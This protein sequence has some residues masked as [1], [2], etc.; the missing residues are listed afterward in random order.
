MHHQT[1]TSHS[2]FQ[3]KTWPAFMKHLQGYTLHTHTHTHT[4]TH[5]H[6]HTHTHTNTHTHTHTH[7]HTHSHTH[8]H[9]G[10]HTHTR[11]YTNTHPYTHTHT[12]RQREGK[13]CRTYLE[14]AK[15]E[16]E[17]WKSRRGGKR[18]ERERK[19]EMLFHLLTITQ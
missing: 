9:T 3:Q 8:T 10:A 1:H 18:R 6:T 12:H 13:V 19:R 4:Q 14:G 15:D 16:T 17:T 7:N 11:A 2:L 5:T